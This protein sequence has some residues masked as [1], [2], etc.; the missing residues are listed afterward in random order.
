MLPALWGWQYTK[1]SNQWITMVEGFNQALKE[2]G[3]VEN[4]AEQ[5]ES[6][7][8]VVAECLLA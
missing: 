3:D 8:Y 1:L 5:I 7:M 6:D 2:I 4:W